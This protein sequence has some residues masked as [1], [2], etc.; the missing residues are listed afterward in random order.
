M[1]GADDSGEM[2]ELAAAIQELRGEMKARLDRVDTE[3][4]HIHGGVDGALDEVAEL[5]RDLDNNLVIIER[6]T[7]CIEQKISMLFDELAAFR[8]EYVLH[9]H[10][11]ASA[12]AGAA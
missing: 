8:H 5:R 4:A 7:G 10:D 11:G 6:A 2:S 3:L 12:G 1:S 9:S